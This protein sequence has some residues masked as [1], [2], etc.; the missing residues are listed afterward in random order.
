MPLQILP[1]PFPG[2]FFP[3]PRGFPAYFSGTPAAFSLPSRRISP[4]QSSR[5]GVHTGRMTLP[6]RAPCGLH[7]EILDP[8]GVA[9]TLP[10]RAPCGLHL[11]FPPQ[12]LDLPDLCLSALRA[13]CIPGALH[14]GSARNPL[15]QR[16]PCGLHLPGLL[17]ISDSYGLCLSALRADCICDSDSYEWHEDLLCLSALRADC[18]AAFYKP[19]INRALCL[20][21]LRADCII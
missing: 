10:Q 1:F 3:A 5:A 16:A 9:P 15:P 18:I 21:A 14:G 2:A 4:R 13:D 7:P 20:S 11:P 17:R 8:A 19:F 6:Q 12:Q